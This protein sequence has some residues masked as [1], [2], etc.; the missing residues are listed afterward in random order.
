[1][2]TKP[3]IHCPLDK[4]FL[5]YIAKAVRIAAE[6]HPDFIML[7]DDTRALT[8]RGG[9]FCPL[10]LSAFNEIVDGNYNAAELYEAIKKDD[11]LARRWDDFQQG[12]FLTLAK[13]VRGSIDAVDPKIPGM[14]C[15]CY[16]DV[17]HAKKMGQIL[18]AEGQ[19]PIV[20]INN[21][22]YLQD[23]EKALP[24]WMY[25]TAIQVSALDDCIVLAE[26]DTCPQ[27]RYATSY[28]M[29][30]T[31]Y[32]WSLLN[33]CSGG[34]LWV[35]SLL[36]NPANGVYYR[37]KLAHFHGFYDEVARMRPEFQGFIEPMPQESPFNA[38]DAPGGYYPQTLG[39]DVIARLGLPFAYSKK[40]ASDNIVVLTGSI[41]PFFSDAEL[42]K[43]LAGRV[44][45]EGEAAVALSKRGFDNLTGCTASVWNLPAVTFEVSNG[46]DERLEASYPVLLKPQQDAEVLSMLHHAAF[47]LAKDSTPLAPGA[48]YFRNSLGGEVISFYGKMGEFNLGTGLFGMLDV[49]FKERLVQ[50]YHPEIWYSEDAPVTLHCFMDRGNRTLCVLNRGLDTLEGL[51]LNGLGDR[52]EIQMLQPDGSWKNVTVIGQTIQCNIS[53]MDIAFFR[54]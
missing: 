10:H 13:T 42:T 46:S 11:K 32:S 3:Y 53:A 16:G 49:K 37:K 18:A 40:I 9:C 54:L 48:V 22:L 51:P 47:S 43:F 20:R 23:S 33:G 38:V 28:Q 21:A 17:R 36:F 4:N 8:G 24:R 19:T 14:Y 1:D 2:G 25:K 15:C 44:F 5:E 39:G 12:A 41:V 30:H 29:L 6:E 7:D 27:K 35:T 31:Q 45:L 26:T 34:K 50:W 52:K